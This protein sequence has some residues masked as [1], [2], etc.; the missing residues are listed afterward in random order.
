MI[1]TMLETTRAYKY[2]Q[3][4]I[5]SG[6]GIVERYVKKQ[7]RQWLDIADG[8]DSELEI[9]EGEVKRVKGILSLAMHPDLGVNL[10][11]GLEDYA[12]LFIFAVLCTC[13]RGTREICVPSQYRIYSI[14]FLSYP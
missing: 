4:C 3:W 1:I 9:N 14:D 5:D 8:K 10:Y 12:L 11:E 6:N 7:C 13:K 2:A